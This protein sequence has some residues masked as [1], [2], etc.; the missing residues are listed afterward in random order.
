MDILFDTLFLL[1]R[2]NEK[3]DRDKSQQQLRV[4]LAC[5]VDYKGQRAIAI[6]KID[7]EPNLGVIVGYSKGRYQMNEMEITR[8]LRY[9][10]ELLN[11]KP[12]KNVDS[13]M[14]SAPISMTIE[15]YDRKAGEGSDE[16]H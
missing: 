2:K 12:N 10:G 1:S 6:S 5:L 14:D 7:I 9:A 16:E 3:G 15:V 13:G 4:P 11:L 8:N